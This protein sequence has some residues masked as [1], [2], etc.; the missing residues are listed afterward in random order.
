MNVDHFNIDNFKSDCILN[1]DQTMI[2]DDKIIGSGSNSLL[3]DRDHT[4]ELDMHT[5]FVMHPMDMD[6]RTTPLMDLEKPIMNITLENLSSPTHT[7]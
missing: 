5:A 1:M 4:D 3:D 2:L 7:N 6:D